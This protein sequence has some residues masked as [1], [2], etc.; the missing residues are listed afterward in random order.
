[1]TSND[2]WT[3]AA[4]TTSTTSPAPAAGWMAG[5]TAAPINTDSPFATQSQ[6]SDAVGSGGGWDPR[7]PFELMEGRMVVLVPKSFRDDAPVPEQWRKKPDEVREEFRVDVVI[8]DGEPFDF[9]YDFKASKDA[10]KEKR[11]WKVETF[12]S[13][14]RE[15]TIANGQ[16][17]RALKGAHKTGSFL[18]GVV[19]RVPVW[20]DRGKYPTPEAL[21]EARKVWIAGLSAGKA[22]PEPRSTWGLDERPFALT[23]ARIA[24]AAAWWEIE[25]K[26]RLDAG[27]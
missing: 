1:V 21:A 12:P 24:L 6:G 13:L 20:A 25:R 8:L 7:V 18:Y 9:E 10:E 22:T 4:T 16:L 26:R 23:P 11:T 2:P 27:E 5:W 17:V 14:H 3:T 19:T 15:Q